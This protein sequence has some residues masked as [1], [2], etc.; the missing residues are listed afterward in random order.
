MPH[1]SGEP[2]L[3]AM[4][5]GGSKTLLVLIN[6]DAVVRDVRRAGG[7]NPFDRPDWRMEMAGLL[8]DL[9]GGIVAAGFGMAGY[10]GSPTVSA[11]QD[12]LLVE[13]G[14]CPYIVCNDVDIACAG[15][16]GGGAGILLLAGTGSMVWATDQT[17]QALRVGGWG[18]LFGDEGSAFWIGR[19][20]LG[21]LT[22]G[23]DGREP[24]ATSFVTPFCRF[25]GFPD[26]PGAIEGALLDWYGG[27]SHA[28]S[29][30]AALSRGVDEL[31]AA[32][33]RSAQRIVEGAAAHLARHV[34]AARRRLRQPDLPWCDAGGAFR[35]ASLRRAVVDLCGVPVAPLLPPVGGA[36]LLAARRAGWDP[37]AAWIA[38]LRKG[39]TDA[40]LFVPALS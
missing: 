37:D 11:C 40:G 16:F 12:D 33:N 35:N 2:C 28:R 3:L 4:D 8:A 29:A 23:L 24:E 36:A 39:L 22:R 21:T 9:P 38:R 7:T 26:D 13:W 30:V 19:E 27:L 10:G 34:D 14:R 17:G 18:H 25:M 31:A 6:R 1:A 20:A 15:A 5:G 32:G